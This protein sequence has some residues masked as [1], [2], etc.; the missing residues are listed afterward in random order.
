MYCWIVVAIRWLLCCLID[1]LIYG[2]SRLSVSSDEYTTYLEFRELL[3][4]LGVARHNAIE[5]LEEHEGLPCSLTR[6]ALVAG[7][8]PTIGG[9][10]VTTGEDVAL[11]A[12]AFDLGMGVGVGVGVRG[13]GRGRGT[14]V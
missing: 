10:D 11:L 4:H 8:D 9:A 1:G 3:W 7:E 6:R 14:R 2:S 12:C 5:R 13:R